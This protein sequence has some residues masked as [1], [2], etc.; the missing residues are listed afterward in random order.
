[1]CFPTDIVNECEKRT[2]KNRPR[3]NES[4]SRRGTT[5]CSIFAFLNPPNLYVGFARLVFISESPLRFICVILMNINFLFLATLVEL[6][7]R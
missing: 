6:P 3:I 7:E 4:R 1:M 5:R 2:M